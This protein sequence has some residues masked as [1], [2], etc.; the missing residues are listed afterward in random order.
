MAGFFGQQRQQQQLQ[1]GLS[2]LAART[3]AAATAATGAKAFPELWTEAEETARMATV[4]AGVMM[5]MKR[6]HDD[7]SSQ[8]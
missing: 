2:E 7:S 3:E 6:A 8:S 5:M 1:V 4:A